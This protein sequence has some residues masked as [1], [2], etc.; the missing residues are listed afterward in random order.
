ML[1]P[2][3]ASAS[4]MSAATPGWLFM[5]APISEI[6]AMSGSRSTPRAPISVASRSRIGSATA[7]S[8][9]GNV[10]VMLVVPCSETFCTIMSM[11]TPASASARNT[12]AA[13]PGWSGTSTITT[14]ASDVSWVTPEMIAFSS[15]ASSSSPIHVP[16][17]SSNVDRT[18]S[19]T[20]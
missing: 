17:P 1:M 20:P 5:P 10:K 18:R 9:F 19:F 11:F 6:F 15:N 12:R 7:T 14:F 16:S 2:A 3:S 4:N 13:T 8:A